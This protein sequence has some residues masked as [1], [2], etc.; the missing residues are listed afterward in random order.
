MLY[1]RHAEQRSQQRSV[2]PEVVFGIYKYG[3]CRRVRG[4]AESITLDREA[5]VLAEDDL[6]SSDYS[7]LSRYV[8]AFLIV[9]EGE[10]ILTVARSTRRFRR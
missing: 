8:G 4:R 7:L 1:S 2:P 10:R 9:G 3:T 6:P 5:L